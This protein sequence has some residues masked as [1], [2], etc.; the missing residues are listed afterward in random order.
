MLPFNWTANAQTAPSLAPA[1]WSKTKKANPL[2]GGSSLDTL[3]L[4]N[5]QF[6]EKILKDSPLQN[7]LSQEL[8]SD[9][10][11][12]LAKSLDKT[13]SSDKRTN[14]IQNFKNKPSTTPVNNSE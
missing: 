5:S 12:L 7:S 13:P 8:D 2:V 3:L 11:L 14:L 4:P 10:S 9:I 6:D 1:P